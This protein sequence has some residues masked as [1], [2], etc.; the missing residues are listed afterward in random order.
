MRTQAEPCVSIFMRTERTGRE[1][2]QNPIR[3]KNLVKEAE[4]RLHQLGVR[5]SES[6]LKPVTELI[7]DGAFWRRQGDG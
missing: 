2:Q 4:D 1:I 7:D 6:L 3:L 5:S